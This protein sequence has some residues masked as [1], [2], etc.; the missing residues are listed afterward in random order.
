MKQMIIKDGSITT[1]KGFRASSCFADIKGTGEREKDD[2]ALIASAVPG[3]AAAVY[4]S[5]KVK[6]AHI[7]VMKE[8]LKG[9]RAQ[10]VI[11][12]SGNANTCNNN[13]TETAEKACGL[14][15]ARLGID[16]GLVLP[17][18]TGIIGVDLDPACFE[19][20]APVLAERLSE[21][22]AHDAAV[23]IMTTD[24]VPKEAAVAFTA[25]GKPCVLGAVA[26]GSGMIHI[27]MGTMLSFMTTDCAIS[28]GMLEKALKDEIKDSYNQVSI[29]GDTSTNDTLAI[30]ANGMAG[31]E[32]IVSE[33]EDFDA[34][35]AALHEISV[36]MAKMIASDGEGAGKLIES[37]VTGA[38]S[39]ETARIVS[40][41]VI[42]SDLVK[43]A[44]FGSDA[45]WGRVLCAVGYAE[46][47]F[48]VD[49]VDV[50]LCSR[51]GVLPVCRKSRGIGFDE[52][53][54]LE[55]LRE[56]AVTI[57]I[58]LHAGGE[59]AYAWGCDLTYDYVK[60][61]GEYRT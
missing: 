4:T 30:L 11:C 14:V 12:N 45:N 3:S 15:G 37:H 5:N 41:S 44:I 13:G 47:E 29:D 34:F 51:K 36:M 52:D 31:N 21:D 10:A 17:A 54:A 9:G 56:D 43:T 32:E 16:P 25:G 35:C 42:R 6:A 22:G 55:I 19:K 40:S 27:N 28:S 59:E 57:E 23:A 46:A 20:A 18:S 7:G 2:V 33:G 26:K 50:D 53:K 38:P 58:C 39:K 49:N 48:P 60:I 8:H 61:N 1:P 24:T